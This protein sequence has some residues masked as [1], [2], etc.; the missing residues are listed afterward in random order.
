M[1]VGKNKWECRTLPDPVLRDRL[2]LTTTDGRKGGPTPFPVGGAA[3]RLK[4]IY[5]R[6]LT[7][8]SCPRAILGFWISIASGLVLQCFDWLVLLLSQQLASLVSHN[9]HTPV[10]GPLLEY[11]R[12]YLQ[13]CQCFLFSG[14]FIRPPYHHYLLHFDS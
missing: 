5:D 14:E 2:F 13:P 12:P 3:A 11:V 7:S 10:S 8:S 4:S 6:L 9:G 1:R